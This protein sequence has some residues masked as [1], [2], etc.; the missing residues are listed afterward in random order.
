[1]AASGLDYIQKWHGARAEKGYWH[2]FEMPDGSI[3]EGIHSLESLRRRLA[4]FPIPADLTGKR[5]LDIG[6]WD[7]F[8]TF[9]MERRGAEVMAIDCW[10][11]PRFREMHAAYGSKVDYRIID[12]FELTPAKIGR[13]DIVLFMGV[14]YHLKHPLLGLERVCALTTNLAAV[15][16]FILRDEE[17]SVLEFYETD[18]MG[19]MTDNW[20]APSLSALMALCR[21]AGFPRVELRGVQDFGASLA[22]YRHWERASGANAAPHLHTSLHAVKGGV[23]FRTDVDEYVALWFDSPGTVTVDE[24]KPEVAGYGMRPISVTLVGEELW[25]ANFKLPPMDHAGWHEVRVRLR[26]SQP[27]NAAVIA[28]DVPVDAAKARLASVCDAATWKAG[29]LDTSKGLFLAFWLEGLPE[30]ADLDNVRATLG[31]QMLHVVYLESSEGKPPGDGRQV[32]ARLTGS[33]APGRF[34][35]AVTVG[36]QPVGELPVDV[37]GGAR[38]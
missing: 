1:M 3:L 17:R 5:V 11:N 4:Q 13:F 20:C 33:V 19:G 2:S 25:Q 22:C 16:S 26:D 9:E 10:D 15:D 14:L 8:F 29:E 18:Q 31:S 6:A 32:N 38:S 7:G 24:V 23:N 12:L 21:V 27:S 30:N 37:K 36:G 34:P 35:L 28:V